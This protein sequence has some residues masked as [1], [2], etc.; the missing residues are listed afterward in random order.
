MFESVKISPSILSAD[1]MNMERDI[2]LLEQGGAAFIHVD[3]MDGHFVPNITV[4]VPFVSGLKK[5]T[6]LPLDVHLMI[7][8]PLEQIPWFLEAGA[9]WITVH[10]ESF[11]TPTVELERAFAMIRE[12][13]A[14]PSLTLR[15]TTALEAIGPYI[16][17]VDM[18]LVMSVNPGFAGQSFIAGTE[19]KVSRVVEMA[20]AAGVD[21]L[22][23]VDG[24]IGAATVERV[25]AAGADVLVAGNAVF[26]S[27]DP[28]VAIKSLI[29]LGTAAQHNVCRS[30]N[31]WGDA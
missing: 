30:Q 13:G 10:I 15:P 31:M 20:E 27:P 14:H 6:N 28:Q 11:E 5:V 24:G 9:D 12:A 26:S 29:R 22:I 7:T 2:R 19:E 4:G 16:T 25:C 21:P 17:L 8:N 1:F 23:Q 18:V 3:V